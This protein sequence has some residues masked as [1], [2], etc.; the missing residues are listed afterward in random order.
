M[1]IPTRP[2]K[3]VNTFIELQLEEKEWVSTNSRSL[4]GIEEKAEF[5]SL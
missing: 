1:N 4:S 3:I 2:T 5:F